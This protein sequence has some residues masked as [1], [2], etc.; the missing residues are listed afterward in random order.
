LRL[1]AVPMI[2]ST[3]AKILKK[4]LVSARAKGTTVIL[5]GVRPGPADVLRTVDAPRAAAFDAALE[6]AKALPV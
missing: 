2:D 6:Q 1:D 4:F 5:C 3:G